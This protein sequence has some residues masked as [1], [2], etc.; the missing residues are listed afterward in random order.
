MEKQEV[1]G[2]IQQTLSDAQVEVEG[3]DCSFTCKVVSSQF[4]GMRPVQ[5]QQAVLGCFGEYLADGRLHAMTVQAFTPEEL[6]A[7]SSS[8]TQLSL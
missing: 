8:L 3:A 4:A 7:R 2:L 5:R 6:A 1:I